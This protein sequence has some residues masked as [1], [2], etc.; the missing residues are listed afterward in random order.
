[1]RSGLW[2]YWLMGQGKRKPPFMEDTFQEKNLMKNSACSNS[3]LY[4]EGVLRE[5]DSRFVLQWITEFQS[6]MQ[7]ALNYCATMGGEYNRI[8]KLWG[9]E[10][11]DQ[12]EEN[13]V[14]ARARTVVNCAGVWAD[15]VN[16]LFKIRS[17]YKHVLS[18][19]V[20][21]GFKRA[22]EHVLPMIFETHCN[23]DV[24]MALPWGPIALWGP[25]ETRIDEPEQGYAV[26]QA[27]IDFLL[28]HRNINLKPKIGEADILS[29]RCGVRPLAV[30]QSY[31]KQEYPLALS[32]KSMIVEDGTSPWVTVYGGKLT[33]CKILA[34]KV[35]DKIAKRITMSP[36]REPSKP[37]PNL[38]EINREIF[39]GLA[40]PVPSL[41][42]CIENECCCTLEDYLRRRT[43][44]S[45]WTAREGL[46]QDNENWESL[47]N[48][49]LKLAD[50]N[51]RKA[52]LMLNKYC[53]GVEENFDRLVGRGI[54]P[55]T[56]L[57][58]PSYDKSIA[59][60]SYGAAG[61]RHKVDLIR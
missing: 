21:L 26:T 43:N 4:E 55:Q 5:S 59:C 47:F 22:P 9:L 37:N 10:L 15:R 33:G 23:G 6:E 14:I 11:A 8:E 38:K 30:K 31:D 46:G 18:K 48:L 3:L 1:M 54:S 42:G 60:R 53:Q 19:G 44:I 40:E 50:G 35:A 20:F 27:D 12:L 49:A 28:E 45:Q 7:V 25:T 61:T 41:D 39:P 57:R 51:P 52:K 58:Q 32:R 34:C 24:L 29:L 36:K 2:L 13:Q 16:D 17:P 56:R